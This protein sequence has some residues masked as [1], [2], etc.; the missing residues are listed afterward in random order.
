M[1]G[2]VIQQQQDLL[3]RQ[4]ITPQPRPC[5]QAWRDLLRAGPGRQQQAGQRIRGIHR[6]L[7]RRV[8]V[9][10][11][12]KLPVREIPGQPVR[13]MHCKC[14]FAD[15]R[16][17]VDRVDPHHPAGGGHPG[18]RAQQLRQLGLTAG[19]AGDITR[20]RPGRRRRASPGRQ[21]L[22]RRGPPAGRRHEQHPHR[23]GQAQRI[24]Q[25]QHRV[26]PRGA[27][28]APLQVTDRPRGQ[29]RRLRQLLLRQPG[30][31]PRLPQQ[32][33]ETQRRLLR[34]RPIAPPPSPA[35]YPRRQRPAT[36]RTRPCQQA[37][38]AHRHLSRSQLT[39]TGPGHLGGS[40]ARRQPRCGPPVP[41]HRRQPARQ[42]RRRG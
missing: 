30:L 6:S 34:H 21:H 26:L 3:P 35:R 24:S 28:H 10:R 8:R 37:Y 33:G 9:Q 13:R 25:Q 32:P 36:A 15:P 31:A 11:Q 41:L 12:E 1:P 4:V 7:S 2:R 38:K 42:R 29:P 20:Q 19:E 39:G 40:R 18:Q 27:V 23:P 14:R 22:A 5:L 17:P 16:H